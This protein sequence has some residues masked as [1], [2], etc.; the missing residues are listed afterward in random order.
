MP[1]SYRPSIALTKNKE[2]LPIQTRSGPP[3]VSDVLCFFQLP[4]ERV[5]AIAVT[6]Q[7]PRNLAEAY[8]LSS[9]I[10]R[11]RSRS[12][13]NSVSGESKVMDMPCPW[14]IANLGHNPRLTTGA[15][16]DSS[17]VRCGLVL[18]IAGMYVP[19][20]RL[21]AMPYTGLIHTQLPNQSIFLEAPGSGTTGGNATERNYLGIVT[22]LLHSTQHSGNFN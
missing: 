9:G 10:L 18:D 19:K 22:F 4:F 12:F 16:S 15:R 21:L 14:R 1:S 11:K 8:Q 3:C 20:I 13:C 7:T 2:P 6:A 5:W 17:V